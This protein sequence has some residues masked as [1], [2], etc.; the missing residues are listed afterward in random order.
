MPRTAR[1]VSNTGYYHV[2]MKG[3][4]NQLIFEED[5][6]RRFYLERLMQNTAENDVAIIAWC[7]MDNHVH[8]CLREE[9]EAMGAHLASSMQSLMTGYAMRFN[10]RTGHEGHV[11]KDRYASRPIEDSQYLLAAVRYIHNN[12]VKAGIC[13]ARDYAWSSYSEYVLGARLCDTGPVL[14]ELGGVEGF[15]EFHNAAPDLRYEFP[16]R[17]RISDGDMLSVATAALGGCKLDEIKAFPIPERNEKLALLRGT[18]L[19]VRQ[20]ARMTGIGKTTVAR[21]ATSS[22]LGH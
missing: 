13:A 20:I 11:F 7:L 10:W 5:A 12:P 15:V 22:I 21:A 18:G 14:E 6:D 2:V 1:A 8:L 4:G 16:E 3:N 17:R 19:S 9:G